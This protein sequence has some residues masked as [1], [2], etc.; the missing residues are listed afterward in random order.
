MPGITERDIAYDMLFGCKAAAELYCTAALEAAHHDVYHMF[1][2]L[3]HHAHETQHRV[4]EYLHRRNEYRV[5]EAHPREIE[6]CRQRMERLAQDH[7]AYA[8]ATARPEYG[9][10]GGNAGGY[11]GGQWANTAAGYGNNENRWDWNRNEPGRT[12]ADWSREPARTTGEWSREPARSGDW[13][14]ESA[15]R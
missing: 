6:E 1:R 4:W 9:R 5:S 7:L 14:R 10:Y 8:G 3:Q 12:S 11:G 2:E 15:R 13:A